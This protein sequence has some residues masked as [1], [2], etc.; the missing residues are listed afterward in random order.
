MGQSEFEALLRDSMELAFDAMR[1]GAAFYVW[2]ASRT[3]RE[4]EDAINKAGAEVKE[5]LIWANSVFTLGRQ[6]YQWKHEPCFYGWKGGAAHDWH[7]DRRQTTVWEDVVDIDLMKKDEMRELLHKI[8]DDD[9]PGT[10]LR[11]DKPARNA[12]H[13]TMKPVA[14]F[15]YLIQNSTL[16]G[17]TVLDVFGGSGT[18]IVACEHLQRRC[19]TMELDPHYCDVIIERWE[20]LTGKT[21]VRVA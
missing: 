14:L 8:L 11:F 13:P 21:A 12:D 17:E 3:Q 16:P 18:S 19:M 20:H 10:V 6:D 5:Q 1:P 7:G 15:A 2:H 9:T 4:F